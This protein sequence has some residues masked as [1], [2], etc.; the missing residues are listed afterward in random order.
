[1]KARTEMLSVKGAQITALTTE[2]NG[3]DKIL[4]AMNKV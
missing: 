1:M 4:Q 2:L 3:K